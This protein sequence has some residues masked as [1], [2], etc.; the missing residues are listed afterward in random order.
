MRK[1]K[2]ISKGVAGLLAAVMMTTM[3]P[4]SLFAANAE[5]GQMTD[6]AID[7]TSTQS[8]VY[9][10]ATL[11]NYSDTFYHGTDMVKRTENM[12]SGKGD[13]N[14][15]TMDI[16]YAQNPDAEKWEGLYF[17]A[18][19]NSAV[20]YSVDTYVPRNVAEDFTIG[21]MSSN[22][23]STGATN[24]LWDGNTSTRAWETIA[25]WSTT[26]YIQLNASG[27][28]GIKKIKL[29]FMTERYSRSMYPTS[30]TV[31]DGAYSDENKVQLTTVQTSFTNSSTN[32]TSYDELTIDLGGAVS[33]DCLTI[34]FEY[35]MWRYIILNEIELYN[36]TDTEKGTQ[37]ISKDLADYNKWS[38]QDDRAKSSYIYSGLVKSTLTNGQ[39]QFNVPQAGV[40]DT[41][42]ASNKE[43]YTNIGLPFI[44]DSSTGYYTF[45]AGVDGYG[46]HFNDSNGNDTIDA[47]EKKDNVNLVL[48]QP[49]TAYDTIGTNS[50]EGFYPF[51][52]YGE[53]SSNAIYH[54]GMNTVIDFTMTADGTV[55]G[56]GGDPITFEFAGDDDVWVFIDGQLVLDLGGIHD[57]V[58]A[59]IDFKENKISMWSTNPAKGSG[60]MATGT[61]STTA[62]SIT[63]LGAILNK[64]TGNDVVTGAISKSYETFAGEGEHKLAIFYLERGR[65]ESNCKI[66]YNLPRQDAF[67]VSKNIQLA[68][69]E[70]Q[71]IT[72]EEWSA[73]NA[74]TFKMRVLN[75][76]GN[77][78][79]G[80]YALYNSSQYIGIY[81]TDS[82]GYFTLKNNQKA[83]F[84]GTLGSNYTVEEYADESALP[85]AIW[86]TAAW[87]GTLTAAKV[88][89]LTG[90]TS[91][92]D[93]TT[94]Q[95]TYNVNNL[96]VRNN[97]S[98][99][100]VINCTN[101]I[102]RPFVSVSGET[103]VIDYGLPVKI[104]IMANDV[105][106]SG[107][108][109]IISNL[110]IPSQGTVK[111]VD[112][113][114]VEIPAETYTATPGYYYLEYTPNTYMSNIEKV[115]YTYKVLS[116]TLNGTEEYA[117]PKGVATIIPATTMYY[118]ENFL[119]SE[120][121]N[122]IK[123][124]TASGFTSFTPE[125]TADKTYQ[126]PGV[127]GTTNDSTYGTDAAYLTGTGDSNGTSYKAD[128]TGGP[129][130]F[131][132]TFTGTGTAFFARTSE[133]S[134]Y[135][136][137]SLKDSEGNSMITNDAGESV[138]YYY[139]D[140]KYTKD[141][142]ENAYNV[143]LPL[144]NIPVFNMNDLPYGTYTVTV[145]IAHP[146]QWY[147][148]QNEFYLD[149]VRVYNPLNMDIS[150]GNKADYYEEVYEAYEKDLETDTNILT[151]RDYMLEMQ[152]DISEDDEIKW[153]D[154]SQV[155]FTD[156]NGSL[157]TASEYK[158]NGP[159][160][161]LYMTNGQCIS[162]VLNDWFSDKPV[163]AKLYIGAK[164]P[165]GK[166]G[167]FKVNGNSYT[168]SNTTDCYYDITSAIERV[169]NSFNGLCV[170]E[171]DSSLIS[172][173]NLKCVGF[174]NFS[175]A[176]MDVV[177]DG[178]E[179][180]D[181]E[182]DT[183]ITVYS[184][185]KRT[186]EE[187]TSG[188]DSDNTNAGNSG[189]DNS[190]TGNTD[191]DNTGEGSTD[192]GNTDKGDTDIDDNDTDN[193][194]TDNTGTPSDDNSSDNEGWILQNI[195][196][197]IVSTVKSIWNKLFH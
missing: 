26:G 158:S 56:N 167:V 102:S 132:Y 176:G 129:A 108:A 33:T 8:I 57:S 37:T 62:S 49:F 169:Y 135:L 99:T 153:T 137:V 4:M 85:S 164:V 88:T 165:E 150:D 10:T 69:N 142:G 179:G 51:N 82:E 66:K 77:P 29:Y 156:T 30:V 128:T 15:D 22:S 184:L 143:N 192:I 83:R 122:Y 80:K 13:Y 39:I 76:E 44:Y 103:V 92:N 94:T 191:T 89:N 25:D 50:K 7:L 48:D 190:D 161:E 61:G 63:D 181:E 21:V 159:K 127:V 116:K 64:T 19:G 20:P 148:D 1:K 195:I 68:A 70:T 126:E 183:N 112:K 173:T 188:N 189:T 93:P 162:F 55:N 187:S 196:E 104:D 18:G 149:G 28:K 172:F 95:L 170:I 32:T 23:S 87:S 123:F 3:I 106:S 133:T 42:N 12:I 67:E 177:I 86:K 107:K 109:F 182:Y 73:L 60:D 141:A 117:Y 136:R 121:K 40:F 9:N 35:N 144:Y 16:A 146:S 14:A 118:E 81:T 90:K 6:A 75:S 84:V 197:K 168:I 41:S 160:Q 174:P 120:G 101:Y 59:K 79:T 186:V 71:A 154:T 130:A 38:G 157:V 131:Q 178:S 27:A 180:S 145:T 138:S 45:D 47:D 193:T 91:T 58:S 115:T 96:E 166:T 100:L 194:G 139:I 134:G 124:S 175:L 46:V 185:L 24:A 54:F 151:L 53:D 34:E 110:S 105:Q 31:F 152:T 17:N 111:V 97:E 119:N 113:D 36:D 125:G 155:M 163:D 98:D 147:T 43:V 2:F 114:G 74:L 5:D 11:F 52:C 65:G 171:V 140:T 72:D 78:V